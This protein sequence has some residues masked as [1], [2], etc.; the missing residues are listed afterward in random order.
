EV[1][2]SRYPFCFTDDTSNPV[3]TRSILPCVPFNDDL[4]RLMLVVTHAPARTKVTWGAGSRVYSAEELARGVNL[5][6]DFLQNP[7]SEAFAQVHAAVAAQQ[8][9]E[10]PAVKSMLNGLAAIRRYFPEKRASLDDLRSSLVQ[11]DQQLNDEARAAI[12]PV[13]HVIELSPIP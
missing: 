3:S 7:F 10:T 8:A 5:A 13:R 12:Q 2:S 11:K 6:G 4:N 9:Y 1:E